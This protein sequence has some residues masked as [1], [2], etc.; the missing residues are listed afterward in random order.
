VIVAHLPPP[1][2]KRDGY[3][4][5]PYAADEIASLAQMATNSG[6]GILMGDFNL[7]DQ[8]DNY[9]LLSDA[10]LTD[11]FRAAGWGFGFT[12]PSRSRIGLLRLLVRIDYIWHSAHFRTIHAWVGPDAGSDHLPVLARLTWRAKVQD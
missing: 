6:P 5:P 11:A 2:L 8:N 12:W 1:S 10:G 7:T 9:T 4:I 3:R